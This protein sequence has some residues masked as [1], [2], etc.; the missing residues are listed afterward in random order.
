MLAGTGKLEWR[1]VSHASLSVLVAS[2]RDASQGSR[3]LSFSIWSSRLRWASVGIGHVASF[4]SH[5]SHVC[6]R[7]YL[8][9]WNVRPLDPVVMLAGTGKLEWRQ[10]S[11]A[12]LSVLVASSRDA[13]QGSRGL[14]FPIWS[15]R[16]RWASVGI[17]YVTSF[18][19]R[20]GNS[21]SAE[22]QFSL[23]MPSVF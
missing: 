17:G 13:S 14:S 19:S 4:V 16:L 11:H 1:Q 10:V 21:G 8:R 5:L 20:S 12:G 2:S 22:C 23:V 9:I 15:S 18:V 3:V 6:A 7:G